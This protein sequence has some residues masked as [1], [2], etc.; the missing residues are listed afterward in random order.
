MRRA[1]PRIPIL[2]AP[3]RDWIAWDCTTIHTSRQ[4]FTEEYR[5]SA[6]S[7]GRCPKPQFLGVRGGFAAA[8]TQKEYR[9]GGSAA[10]APPPEVTLQEPCE[11][12][13]FTPGVTHAPASEG[14][15]PPSRLRGQAARAPRR[16]V[17][18]YTEG[19]LF[20]PGVT[21]A[22]GSAGGPPS[23]PL[24]GQ[25]APAPSRP[26]G[27]A[28]QHRNEHKV[29]P[30]RAAPSQTLPRAGAW[31]NPVSPHPSS[32]AYVHVRRHVNTYAIPGGMQGGCVFRPMGTQVRYNTR[33]PRR[34]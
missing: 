9:G 33:M 27:C 16:H 13:L 7:L 11:G 24:R 28:A 34:P 8:H 3:C 15:S 32:R 18:T 10:P 25:T 30:G 2:F 12:Y 29:V 23:S 20:T 5:A 26:C 17:N 31:G 22:P 19:Y 21:H 4:R 1:W 6:K 14:V